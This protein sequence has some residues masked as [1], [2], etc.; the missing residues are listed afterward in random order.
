[1]E[2]PALFDLPPEANKYIK[3]ALGKN[4][5]KYPK[6]YL[7]WY[8]HWETSTGVIWRKRAIKKLNLIKL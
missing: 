1:M 5:I 4:I 6:L 7:E 8:R 2:A 3:N